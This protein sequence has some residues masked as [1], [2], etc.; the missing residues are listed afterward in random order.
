[1]S[2][3]RKNSQV[4]PYTLDKGFNTNFAISV[5]NGQVAVVAPW[6]FSRKQINQ[7][8]IDKKN[9]ILQKLREYEEINAIR[10][11]NLESKVVNVFGE[12]YYLK[13]SYKVINNPELYMEK[14]IIRINLPVKYRNIDNTRIVNLV[15][16]KF[17]N[18][19]A[20]KEI[21]KLMEKYRIT[22]GI[23]P[24]DYKIKKMN[25][26]L[27]KFIEENKIIIINPDIIKYNKSILEYIILHEFCHL[28]YKTHAK[29]FY[30]IIEKYIKNYKN[31]EKEIKGLF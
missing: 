18:R 5:K 3:L 23:A 8:I 17:Y 6:Y 13:I 9:L 11:A 7:I 2:F 30:K 16:E 26:C 14:N 1:M 4:I 15:L 27:G 31:I 25:R 22:L 29:G 19:L 10:K 21:E 28:L 12:N 24:E 20:E